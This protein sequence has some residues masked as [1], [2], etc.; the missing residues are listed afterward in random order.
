M[1]FPMPEGESIRKAVRWI[2]EK[3]EERPRPSLVTLIEQA[4]QTFNLSPKECHWLFDFFSKP[5]S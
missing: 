2:S 5:G 1:T 4:G 3:R